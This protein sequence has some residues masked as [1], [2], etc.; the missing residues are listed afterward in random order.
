MTQNSAVTFFQD[1]L[2]FEAEMGMVVKIV[3]EKNEAYLLLD[4]R[5]PEAFAKGHIPGAR[6][7]PRVQLAEKLAELPKDKTIIT[8]CYHAYCFASAKAA[9]ELAKAG[10]TVMEMPGGFDEWEKRNHPVHVHD[11]GKSYIVCDC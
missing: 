3:S 6:N 4:V 10:F 7:I 9:L 1:K 11:D 2:A 5:S 8:Y